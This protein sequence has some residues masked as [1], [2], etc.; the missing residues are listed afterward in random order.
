MDAASGISRLDAGAV[1]AG[2]LSASTNTVT[3]A[4]SSSAPSPHASA[5]ANVSNVELL[6]G[7]FRIRA[8]TLAAHAIATCEVLDSSSAAVRLTINDVVLD[9]HEQQ[10][11]PL[12]GLGV[13]HLNRV[14]VEQGRITRRALWLETA[15]GS[16]VVAEAVAGINRA[17]P[18]PVARPG[19]ARSVEIR[20][21]VEQRPKVDSGTGQ[22]VPQAV[23]AVGPEQGGLQPPPQE[24]GIRSADGPRSVTAS[25]AQPAVLQRALAFGLPLLGV[26]AAALVVI[27]FFRRKAQ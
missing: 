4:P 21:Q 7:G 24:N 26:L 8:H 12:P 6:V 1:S 27:G 9:T 14:F 17:C 15:A 20:P 23:P 11:H 16:I 10:D 13:L 3:S 19:I 25:D 5:R 18:P 22:G 2:V